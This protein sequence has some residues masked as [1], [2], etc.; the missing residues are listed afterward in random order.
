[1]SQN[2]FRIIGLEPAAIITGS[3]LSD[4]NYQ[5]IHLNVLLCLT[6]PFVD[7]TILAIPLN[8]LI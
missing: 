8:D 1:M 2:I 3:A 5:Q 6:C 4:L 7:D